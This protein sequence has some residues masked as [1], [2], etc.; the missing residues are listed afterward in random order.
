MAIDHSIRPAAAPAEREADWLRDL[1]AEW[2]SRLE[3][4]PAPSGQEEEWRRTSL[5]GLPWE[6]REAAVP[7]AGIF[8]LPPH[9]AEAGVAFGDLASVAA[10]RQELLKRHLGRRE[11]LPAQAHFWALA[12]A[13]WQSG[14]FLYVPRGVEVD[15]TLVASVDLGSAPAS[16]PITLV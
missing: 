9:L 13:A 10:D 1:R 2:H 14:T 8:D 12:H 4:T 11:T 3:A 15:E 16:F 5:D 6:A 7:A